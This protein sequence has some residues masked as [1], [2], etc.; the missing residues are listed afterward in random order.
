MCFVGD[1]NQPL[2]LMPEFHCQG[3]EEPV[4]KKYTA[5][6]RCAKEDN[7]FRKESGIRRKFC[8]WHRNGGLGD[9]GKE[10]KPAPLF[11]MQALCIKM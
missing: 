9:K 2:F 1:K 5:D 3:H 11:G 4:I 8:R 6:G 10:I 7:L